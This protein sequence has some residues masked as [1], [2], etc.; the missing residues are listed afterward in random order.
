MLGNNEKEHPEECYR[1][2]YQKH[3]PCSCG[4]KLVCVN[5]KLSKP[6]MYVL[7]LGKKTF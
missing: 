2:E 4:Y 6:F 1:N 3:I 5:D 7:Y